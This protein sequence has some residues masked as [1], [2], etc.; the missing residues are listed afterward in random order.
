M[1]IVNIC[2]FLEIVSGSPG[3]LELPCVA[4][5]DLELLILLLLSP[6][7]GVH[8]GIHYQPGFLSLQNPFFA[9]RA[10]AFT[11]LH[12]TSSGYLFMQIL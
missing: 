2:Y 4:K 11:P 8:R 3:G 1:F 9:G 10:A 7:T 12:W 5:D 6:N